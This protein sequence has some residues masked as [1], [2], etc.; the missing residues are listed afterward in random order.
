MS[1]RKKIKDMGNIFTS[2]FLLFS[3]IDTDLP[4]D[5]YIH[6]TKQD[7]KMMKMLYKLYN[8]KKH[9]GWYGLFEREVIRIS[10]EMNVLPVVTSQEICEKLSEL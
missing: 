2:T 8:M 7:R 3:V 9:Y 4:Q 6:I 5:R 1:M 10:V